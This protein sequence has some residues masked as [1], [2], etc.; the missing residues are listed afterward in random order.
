MEQKQATLEMIYEMLKK[1]EMEVEM[2]NSRLNWEGEFDEEENAEF[3]EG[4]KRAWEEIDE[5]KYAKYNSPEEFLD[6]FK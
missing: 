1:I 6:S 5:G 4:T 3:A 2:I